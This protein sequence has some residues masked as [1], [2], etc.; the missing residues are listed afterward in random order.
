M[1]TLY[2]SANHTYVETVCCCFFSFKLSLCWL[3]N[4]INLCHWSLLSI[5][6]K[7][8]KPPANIL[9]SFFAA[10]I[11]CTYGLTGVFWCISE[12]FG[13][14]VHECGS[15]RKTPG[16]RVTIRRDTLR[17]CLQ[18]LAAQLEF[19][20]NKAGGETPEPEAGSKTPDC[21]QAWPL[22]PWPPTSQLHCGPP[23]RANRRV[24]T[25]EIIKQKGK[26][27]WTNIISI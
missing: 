15:G 20:F 9:S 3:L 10:D 19:G 18:I 11:L 14:Y 12:R 16:C 22:Y 1:L 8:D 2:I 4:A 23:D 25:K 5:R 17:C 21:P 27:G 26:S 13:T 6:I 7:A 24:S